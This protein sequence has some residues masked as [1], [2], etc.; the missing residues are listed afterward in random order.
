LNDKRVIS[1]PDAGN[2]L[3]KIVLLIPENVTVNGKA[4]NVSKTAFTSCLGVVAL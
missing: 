2:V 4:F 1:N 3:L